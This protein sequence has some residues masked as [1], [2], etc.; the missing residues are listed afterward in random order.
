M[1]STESLEPLEI[2][3]SDS[4]VV[5]ISVIPLASIRSHKYWMKA[6]LLPGLPRTYTLGCGGQQFLVEGFP[7][8]CDI[9]ALCYPVT[10]GVCRT[11]ALQSEAASSHRRCTPHSAPKRQSWQR[12][13]KNGGFCLTLMKRRVK[14]QNCSGKFSS[15]QRAGDT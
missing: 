7:N 4:I 11:S 9:T 15:S 12:T 6:N 13:R 10:M 8:A 14:S 2:T 3:D 5:F 1:L